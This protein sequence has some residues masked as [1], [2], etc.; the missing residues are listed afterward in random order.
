MNKLLC[1]LVSI[2]VI[3]INLKAQDSLAFKFDNG[4][5]VAFK[6]R[7]IPPASE[8]ELRKQYQESGYFNPK[9]IS[10]IVRTYT[11]DEDKISFNYGME[12]APN[13]DGKTF[14]VTFKAKKNQIIKSDSTDTTAYQTKSL[15]NYPSNIVINDGDT[16]VL[17]ILQNPKTGAKIQ[18]LIKITRENKPFDNYFSEFEEPADFSLSDVQLQLADFKLYINGNLVERPSTHSIRARFA[19]FEFNK[20]GL[21]VLTPT[22]VKGYDFKK[23]G[24]INEN[25]LSFTLNGDKF[26]IVSSVMIL[27]LGKKWNLWAAVLPREHND[28]QIPE[29]IGFITHPSNKMEE[30]VPTSNSNNNGKKPIIVL[31]MNDKSKP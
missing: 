22:P 27:G 17:D 29:N 15:P 24:V 21:L 18:D 4:I 16:I 14:T 10:S 12:I 8:D 19:G 25:K 23:V 1:V 6:S 3:S 26:E 2:L 30:F 5:N 31:R 11:N 9:D 7:T 28:Y 13:V 20:Y